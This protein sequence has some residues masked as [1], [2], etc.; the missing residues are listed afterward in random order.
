MSA[1]PVDVE[2][3]HNQGEQR[4]EAWVEGKLAGS[5]HYRLDDGP[6]VFTHTEVEPE[7]EGR[8]IAGRLAEA[9]L[10]D[11]RRSGRQ[12]I[13]L[14]PYIAGYVRRHPGLVDLVVPASRYRVE[15]QESGGA[16]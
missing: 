15:P 5:A 9:A 4:Y 8:G 1:G 6:V 10:G 13:P 3:R 16:G 11:A 12:V 2:I 7:F 14:C